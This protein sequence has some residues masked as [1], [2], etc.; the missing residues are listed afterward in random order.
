MSTGV[1][2]SLARHYRQTCAGG[3]GSTWA[4]AK[5]WLSCWWCKPKDVLAL[6]RP[7]GLEHVKSAEHKEA[8]ARARASMLGRAS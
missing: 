6:C 4:G 3:C 1:S 7:C 2:S 8:A 5:C